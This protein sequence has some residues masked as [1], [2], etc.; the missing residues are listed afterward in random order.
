MKKN[1]RMNAKIMVIKFI[2]EI[3]MKKIFK[4]CNDY[5]NNEINDFNERKDISY[6]IFNTER[7]NDFPGSNGG[8]NIIR[9]NNEVIA[10]IALGNLMKRKN[11]YI[12]GKIIFCTTNCEKID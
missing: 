8:Y 9:I 12:D 7:Y 1:Y 11:Y 4:I 10:L 2:P 6:K 5:R 3:E